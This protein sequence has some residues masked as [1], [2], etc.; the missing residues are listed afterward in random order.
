MLR[1][2]PGFEKSEIG[3]NCRN[4]GEISLIYGGRNEIGK[5]LAKTE[6]RPKIDEISEKLPK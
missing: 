6:N 4:F 2:Q 1:L 5:D 3:N